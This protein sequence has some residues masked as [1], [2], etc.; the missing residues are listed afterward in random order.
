MEEGEN[1]KSV[2][3]L[4]TKHSHHQNINVTYLCRDMFPSGNYAKSIS[5]NAHYVVAFKNP[6]DKLGMR[7]LLLQVF[8]TRC[9]EV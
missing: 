2:L 5:R 7:N 9:Q 6:W 1:Y 3:E 4:F 8:P